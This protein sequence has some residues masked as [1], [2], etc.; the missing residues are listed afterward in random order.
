MTTLRPA[1]DADRP[2]LDR[3][4]QLFR[5]DLSGLRGELP[6]PDG[7]FRRERLDAAF[8]DPDRTAY[9]ITQAGHPAGLAIV[10]GL[11][12]PTLV[13]NSFFVVRGARRSG[14]GTRAVEQLVEQHPGRWEVAFQD[15]N[16]AAVAFWRTTATRL[17]GTAWREQRRP[18]PARPDLPPDVWI[19]FRS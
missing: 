16:R 11:T 10:R 8:D 18:V 7:T 3:L 12:E 9:V 6:A 14:V 4:W 5:H 19:S 15:G 17:A 2:V 1:T 13:I